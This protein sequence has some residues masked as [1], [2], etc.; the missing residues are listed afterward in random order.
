MHSAMQSIE[1]LREKFENLEM[2]D[3]REHI[4]LLKS[5]LPEV[6]SLIDCPRCEELG[7]G[8]NAFEHTQEVMEAVYPLLK[9]LDRREG[10][11]LYLAAFLHDVGRPLRTIVGPDGRIQARRHEEAGIPLARNVLYRM[12]VNCEIR[13]EVIF[14]VA[15]H[16]APR[17]YYKDSYDKLVY[18][19]LSLELNT[20]LLYLLSLADISRRDGSSAEEE[21]GKIEEFKSR[22]EKYDIFGK[23][24]SPL[25]TASDLEKAG[26]SDP[27]E[28]KKIINEMLYKRISGEVHDPMEARAWLYIV[29]GKPFGKLYVPVGI[30][31][32][33]KTFWINEN[34]RGI[35]V[36]SMDKKR[37]EIL[38]DPSD[39][40]QNARIYNLCLRE[41]DRALKA[42]ET[43]VWDA[44]NYSFDRRKGVLGIARNTHSYVIMI[45]FDVPLE[46]ALK[47][48][49]N[50]QRFVPERAVRRMYS[51][52]LFPRPFEAEE[53][54]RVS[55]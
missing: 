20:K 29:K 42:G 35:R 44:T 40:S 17:I 27:K 36:I 34:L 48:N 49:R 55:D 11:V 30:P 47:R 8:G 7:S 45:C 13:E 38:S 21:M 6:Y 19:R 26:V 39:Q 2:I 15:R 46:V 50:R 18:L 22:C 10:V 51:N 25:I 4:P 33:G 32:S 28:G 43:V 31:G 5:Q 9:D 53:I 54:W 3:L 14:L 1:L 52:L 41:L 24:A 23:P 16:Y 12:G 37:E